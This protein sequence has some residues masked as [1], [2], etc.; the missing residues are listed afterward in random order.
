MSFKYIIRIFLLGLVPVCIVVQSVGRGLYN[1][2]RRHMADSDPAL[3]PPAA[4][5][6]H[7]TA[8]SPG[9]LQPPAVYLLHQ[10]KGLGCVGGAISQH[11]W[12]QW[13]SAWEL[14]DPPFSC[15]SF[16]RVIWKLKGWTFIT[17]S[18]HWLTA[19]VII[20][21]ES[22]ILEA[23]CSHAATKSKNWSIIWHQTGLRTEW[24]IA[25]T[26][27]L[28]SPEWLKT[29]PISTRKQLPSCDSVLLIGRKRGESSFYREVVSCRGSWPACWP[30][31]IT[32]NRRRAMNFQS[33][34]YFPSSPDGNSFASINSSRVYSE[35]VKWCS[36]GR[37]QCLR[38]CRVWAG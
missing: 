7:C 19:A 28:S 34:L 11:G 17:G 38:V 2:W 32:V 29:R 9:P 16:Q 10:N 3:L 20:E 22:L 13:S 6:L 23:G 18:L 4:P 12:G 14:P 8:Q 15:T 30:V 27:M 25:S 35:R 21:Y 33:S 24:R 37:W 26:S 5:P 36:D 1:C 31:E